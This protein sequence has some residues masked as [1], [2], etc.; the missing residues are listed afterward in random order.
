MLDR[1]DSLS[2][3]FFK[4]QHFYF[5]KNLAYA[6]IYYAKKEMSLMK[7]HAESARFKLE[8]VVKEHSG[9]PKFQRLLQESLLGGTEQT[10]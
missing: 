8:K 4:E 3:D 9:D 10:R 2:Y 5:Q 1:L 6:S 7:K